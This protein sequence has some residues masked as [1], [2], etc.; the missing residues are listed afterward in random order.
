MKK[1][2]FTF[3]IAFFALFARSENEIPI[4]PDPPVPEIYISLVRIS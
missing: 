2:V 3:I 1:F 4:T